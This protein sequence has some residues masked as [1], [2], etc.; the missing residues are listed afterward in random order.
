MSK[1]T[2]LVTGS[3]DGIGLALT[4][5]LV[6]DHG[7]RVIMTSRSEE[8]GTKARTDVKAEFPDAEVDLLQLDVCES[9]SVVAAAGKVKEMGVTLYALVNNAGVGFNAGGDVIATNFYGPKLC[10]ESFVDLIDAEKGR[11]VNVSSGAASMWLRNQDDATKALFSQ[12]PVTSFE[13]LED[14]VKKNKADAS[15]GG[16]G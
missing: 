9:S 11:I 2:I 1:K 10:S 7:C 5:V 13:A 14:S 3:N 6:R 16:Y 8:R 4:K 15:M 12:M